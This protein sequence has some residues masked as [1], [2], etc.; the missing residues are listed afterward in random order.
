MDKGGSTKPWKIITLN[1]NHKQPLEVPYVLKLFTTKQVSQQ[2]SIGKE[3]L[4]NFLATEFDLIVPECG[5][6][7]LTS[8]FLA[9]LEKNQKNEF[10]HRHQ[11][12][13]FASKLCTGAMLYNEHVGRLFPIK[14]YATIFAFDFLTF[15]TDRGGFRDKPNLLVDDEGFILIDHELTFHFISSTD[16]RPLDIII[17]HVTKNSVPP[18][19]YDKHI[20]Y[21][22]LKQYKGSKKNI[23]DEAREYLKNLNLNATNNY[24]GILGNFDISIGSTVLLNEYLRFMKQNADKFI[25]ILIRLVS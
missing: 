12:Y 18:F 13:T 16:R 7:K 19:A 17:N 20:F 23:F 6:V 5:F 4:C 8:P 25:N 1:P 2:D 24:L 21:R 10:L 9:T 3:F 11:G 22:I 15:N 14:Y